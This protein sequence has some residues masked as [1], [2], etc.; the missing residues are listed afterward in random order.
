MTLLKKFQ[1]ANVLVVGDIML[2]QYFVGSTTRISPEAPVPIVKVEKEYAVLGGAANVA[3]NISCL[4]GKTT[5]MGFSGSDPKALLLEEK[6]SASN[7]HA[8]LVSTHLPT[9]VKL[10]ILSQHQQLI[11]LD[12]EKNYDT[13]DHF[14]LLQ[15]MKSYLNEHPAIKTILFSDYAKG[16]L[17]DV[18]SLIQLAKS[19]KIRTLIDPKGNDFS[20]YRGAYLIT[21][22]YAEF[23]AVMG[24]CAN[25]E[26]IVSKGKK[27]LKEYDIQNLLITRGEH[28][29]MLID[30]LGE[31]TYEKT[32][33]KEVFDVTGAGDTVIAVLGLS[34]AAKHP[35]KVAMHLS[36]V[37]AGIVVGKIGTTTVSPKEFHDALHPNEKKNLQTGIFS[38]ETLKEVVLSAK[39]QGESIVFT[40]GCFDLLHL[41]HVEY[42]KQAKALGDRLIVA[43]NSD[44]SIQKLKG[45]S[46]PVLPQAERSALLAELSCVDWVVIFDEDTPESLLELLKPDILVK[47]G[48]YQESEIV[49]HEIVKGYGGKVLPLAFIPGRSTT[50]IIEKIKGSLNGSH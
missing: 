25:E 44:T 36:N 26:E 35:L 42:L 27:L 50:Q 23:T 4:G 34:L 11:R 18:Q 24:P 48:D 28:G 8:E 2:D 16:C 40:N 30:E 15:K 12:F 19:H 17:K 39:N 45:Q 21:P 49:G 13:A 10:R 7:I 29:M 32:L 20:K 9:I 22:N 38:R 37:A 43:I 14:A 31:V 6:L 33:A 47:G 41:G 5:L 1:D 3:N 46:R